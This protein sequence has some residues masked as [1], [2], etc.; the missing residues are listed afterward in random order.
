MGKCF[1]NSFY[2][3]NAFVFFTQMDLIFLLNEFISILNYG[4]SFNIIIF[5]LLKFLLEKK[6]TPFKRPT[7]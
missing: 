6:K 5:S 3:I 7:L 4:L 1:R 2:R